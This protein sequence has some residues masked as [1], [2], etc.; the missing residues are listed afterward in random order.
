MENT[1]KSSPKT[2]KQNLWRVIKRNKL[3]YMLLLPAVGATFVFAYMPLPGI[4]VAFKNYRPLL[5]PWGSPWA[6]LSVF[7]QIFSSRMIMN[8]IGNTV[9]L[10]VL[11]L[12]ITFPAPIVLALMLNELRHVFYKRTIQTISYLP[13]FLSWISVVG[14]AQTM[15]SLYGV[16]NDM[17]VSLFG[18]GFERIM[19]LGKQGTFVPLYILLNLWKGIGWGSIIYLAAI[20]GID[21]QIY[22]AA[23]VDGANRLQQI[24]HI[25][26]PGISQTAILL[27]ILS[28]GGLFGSNF[29]LVYALQNPYI[30]F[31]VISTAVYKVG[32]QQGN[33]PLGTAL[34][35]IQGLIAMILVMSANAISRKVTHMALW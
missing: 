12:L 5:G 19:F 16:F 26:L 8:S 35:L 23:I 24:W 34:N 15:L 10:N 33:Y 1:E 14:L 6:G 2:R 18:S 22:E 13:Y 25:T 4:V 32:L 7:K 28:I 30:N 3:I 11:T 31:E 9:S 20:S 29:E 21:T 27:L 17:L